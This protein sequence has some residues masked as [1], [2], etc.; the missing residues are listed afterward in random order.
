VTAMLDKLTGYAASRLA[1]N[2]GIGGTGGSGNAKG[3]RC[4]HCERNRL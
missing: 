2:I 3:W 1:K 4:G